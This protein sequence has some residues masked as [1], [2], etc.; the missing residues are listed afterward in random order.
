MNQTLR[1]HLGW[2]LTSVA[3]SGRGRHLVAGGRSGLWIWDCQASGDGSYLESNC[4]PDQIAAMPHS[5]TIAFGGRHCDCIEVLDCD[6][7]K[8]NRIDL[9]KPVRALAMGCSPDGRTLAIGG[10][11]SILTWDFEKQSKRFEVDSSW[12]QGVAF[13]PDGKV[14]AVAGTEGLQ[15]LNTQTGRPILGSPHYYHPTSVAYSADGTLIAVGGHASD[16]AVF[17]VSTNRL[18]WSGRV[19]GPSRGPGPFS[20]AAGIVAVVFIVL[21]LRHAVADGPSPGARSGEQ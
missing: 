3:F 2:Y 14:L 9:G 18:L 12:T 16:V 1:S 17:E 5:A 19:A 20:A 15:S 4:L 8:K 11:D 6:S 7:G 10:S 21:I 13:S